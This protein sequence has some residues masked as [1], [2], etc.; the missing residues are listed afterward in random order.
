[1]QDWHPA[2]IKAALEKRGWTL[3]KLART[4][5]YDRKSPSLALKQPWP[6]MEKL[7]AEA[8]GVEPQQIWPSRYHRD[9]TP[10][11]RAGR[12]PVKRVDSVNSTSR[13]EL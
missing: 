9:G 5:G 10:N 13:E 2:D 11:R 6:R 1:M 4:H 12:P 7:I 3:G 8:I